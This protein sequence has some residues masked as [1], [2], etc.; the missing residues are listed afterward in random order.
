MGWPLYQ[1]RDTDNDDEE[2]HNFTCTIINDGSVETPLVV[3]IPCAYCSMP[4]QKVAT[5]VLAPPPPNNWLQPEDGVH[6]MVD[7]DDT[8][9][10][11]D[12]LMFCCRGLYKPC[13]CNC[14]ELGFKAVH[15]FKKSTDPSLTPN[16]LFLRS[17]PYA[18]QPHD[19]LKAIS[20]KIT[21]TQGPNNTSNNASIG[22]G[23]DH[24]WCAD[25]VS[26]IHQ[27]AFGKD[28]HYLT[29]RENEMSEETMLRDSGYVVLPQKEYQKLYNRQFTEL[30]TLKKK[31]DP[32]E[33][34]ETFLEA[35]L[36][37]HYPQVYQDMLK[38][39]YI[40]TGSNCIESKLNKATTES[41]CQRLNLQVTKQIDN[42]V[43]RKQKTIKLSNPVCF[44]AQEY[45]D[46]IVNES[47]VSPKKRH[48]LYA[49]LQQLAKHIPWY[50]KDH[51]MMTTQTDDQQQQK[52]QRHLPSSILK[53]SQ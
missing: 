46:S 51:V 34:H 10:I 48:L 3:Q 44:L 13:T 36:K 53:R 32:E 8:I 9:T 52:Q 40:M 39:G 37:K 5:V 26:F 7:N 41:E 24:C 20:N 19:Q 38:N 35:T 4:L 23:D 45:V 18:H 15:T 1:L 12:T 31:V 21:K 30:M 29:T 47:S 42:I 11:N 16:H 33:K 22:K 6:T 25:N 43:S 50:M 27:I 14:K 2:I 49:H 17:W 28:F